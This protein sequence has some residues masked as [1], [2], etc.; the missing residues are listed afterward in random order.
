MRVYV[1]NKNTCKDKHLEEEVYRNINQEKVVAKESQKEKGVTSFFHRSR[2]VNEFAKSGRN[3]INYDA[4][5]ARLRSMDPDIQKSKGSKQP[6]INTNNM[7][8]LRVTLGRAVSKFMLYNRIAFNVV[9]SPFTQP[10]LDV[11]AQVGPGV[12]GPSSYEV[13][14]V[15][16]PMEHKEMTEWIESFKGCWKERGVTIMC[17]I[18]RAHV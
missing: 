12:K 15:Y 18:G 14:E 5:E 11:A 16:L 1:H 10:M 17:E 9:E 13:A 4:P 3:W 6:R 8:K 2:S 7:K